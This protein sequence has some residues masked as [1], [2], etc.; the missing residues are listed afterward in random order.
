MTTG[1]KAAH[2]QITDVC[3]MLVTA[4]ATGTVSKLEHRCSRSFT[5]QGCICSAYRRGSRGA[6]RVPGSR[7]DLP[8]LVGGAST[9]IWAI[10]TGTPAS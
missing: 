1:C 6:P 2:F 3:L 8:V 10:E 5:F 4:T 9:S 7:H